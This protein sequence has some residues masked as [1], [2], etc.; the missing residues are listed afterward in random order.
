MF[1]AYMDFLDHV[2]NGQE[3]DEGKA[4]QQF[5]LLYDALNLRDDAA[6]YQKMYNFLAD[7]KSASYQA[8][9]TATQDVMTKAREAAAKHMS[10]LVDD[11]EGA[12]T[13]KALFEMLARMGVV[14][15]KEDLESFVKK[16][17]KPR[18]R[19]AETGELL[20]E[21]SEL[22]AAATALINGVTEKKEAK[23]EA[24]TESVS[25]NSEEEMLAL[26]DVSE[27]NTYFQNLVE[28]VYKNE[29]AR[30]KSQ[31]LEEIS[32]N[33]FVASERGQAVETQ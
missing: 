16:G 27:L 10:K 12:H 1:K 28:V 4:K 24:S 11:V 25:V 17:T 3:V 20:K 32:F 13:Y 14:V 5:E 30:R 26:E 7:P 18:L 21:D 29:A 8:A 22:H 6:T 33:E 15:D 9:F 2:A 23:E 31:G 19:S